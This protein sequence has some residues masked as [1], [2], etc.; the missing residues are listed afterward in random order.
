MT[1]Y[2][3]VYIETT[4]DLCNL[5]YDTVFRVCVCVTSNCTIESCYDKRYFKLQQM[6][7]DLKG[8]K[9][10]TA[11]GSLVAGSIVPRL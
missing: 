8:S 7:L 11:A 10:P 9:N 2:D 5:Q 3:H 6:L 4:K 1:I